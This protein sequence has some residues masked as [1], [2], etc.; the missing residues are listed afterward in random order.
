MSTGTFRVDLGGLVELLSTHLYSGPEVYLRELMQNAVDAITARSHLHTAT[1]STPAAPSTIDIICPEADPGRC[2]VLRDYGVGLTAAEATELLSTIGAS[3]KRV[4]ADTAAHS[5][6][7]AAANPREFLGQFGIGMLS[8]FLVSDTIHVRSRSARRPDAETISWSG[9]T[10]GT[11]TVGIAE[12]P[13]PSPGT[14]IRLTPRA[15]EPWL[16]AD[17]VLAILSRYTAY[18]PV[19][20]RVDRGDG[21]GLVTRARTT[22]PWEADSA[23]RD[24]FCR[25]QF[26]FHPED[27]F[28]ADIPA[29]AG[30]AAIFIAS[31]TAA[32]AAKASPAAVW[33]RGMLVTE[34][35]AKL[36]PEWAYFAR[37]ALGATS[38]STTASREDLISDAALSASTAQISAALTTWLVR[39]AAD[40]PQA[41]ADF[42]R[43]HAAGLAQHAEEDESLRTLLVNHLQLTTTAG[44]HTLGELIAIGRPIRYAR[45]TA[46]YRSLAPLMA[47]GVILID[48]GV[49]YIEEFLRSA[50]THFP[51]ADIA[52]VDPQQVTA[53]LEQAEA[54]IQ[55]RARALLFLAEEALA[56]V[57]CAVELRS[58]VPATRRATYL[59]DPDLAART[60]AAKDTAEVGDM[61]GDVLGV[62]DPFAGTG[63]PTL[64]LNAEHPSIIGLIEQSR[65]AT[66]GAAAALGYSAAIASIRSIYVECLVTGRYPLDGQVRSWLV[67]LLA[68]RIDSAA[69][70]TPPPPQ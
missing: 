12:E 62:I 52:L 67:D 29:A 1:R 51:L 22:P 10:T 13:L 49:G 11:F 35:A 20:V 7:V 28:I 48:A 15:Q 68:E 63:R 54:G 60:I 70:P 37:V 47:E 26:G 45:T 66:P 24:A 69:G 30:K 33:V 42:L 58:F 46:Q 65:S 18:L 23:A 40:F 21:Q 50:I 41:T 34:R 44:S 56:E 61:W 25:E 6:L 64:V 59:P 36:V 4:D 31:S 9:H 57:E 17:T 5:D 14:E 38:L 53:A 3:S 16:S 43:A 55:Q 19:D 2:F 32:A 39:R 27:S 8:G